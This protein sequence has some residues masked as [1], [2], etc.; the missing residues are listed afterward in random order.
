MPYIV[1]KRT[2]KTK[3][4]YIINEMPDVSLVLI[5]WITCGKKEIVVKQAAANPIFYIFL[6]SQFLIFMYFFV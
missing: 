4:I 3:K 1:H 6:L 2:P 5:T